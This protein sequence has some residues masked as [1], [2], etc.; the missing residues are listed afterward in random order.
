MKMLL[1]L[2]CFQRES[3]LS[4]A[5]L[6]NRACK[7]RGHY[8]S[9]LIYI[10]GFPSERSTHFRDSRQWSA[11]FASAAAI[12]SEPRQSLDML[13]YGSW[14]ACTRLEPGGLTS[15]FRHR[16]PSPWGCRGRVAAVNMLAELLPLRAF[17]PG[18][19]LHVP[20]HSARL[21]SLAL[22]ESPRVGWGGVCSR[23]TEPGA[24]Q[25]ERR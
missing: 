22:A 7:S 24:A 13:I 16:A 11:S 6:T 19:R 15:I 5:S 12:I 14:A 17:K 20:P 3:T 21:P 10:P 4:L 2:V 9:R 25:R 8:H 18:L 1:L 23:T